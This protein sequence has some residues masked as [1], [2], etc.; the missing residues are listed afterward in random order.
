MRWL[1]ELINKKINEISC[2]QNFWCHLAGST[3][4]LILMSF[5]ILARPE[6]EFGYNSKLFS[7]LSKW[8]SRSISCNFFFINSFW[9][10]INFSAWIKLL[11]KK[12]KKNNKTADA[13]PTLLCINIHGFNHKTPQPN[14]SILNRI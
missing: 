2:Q 9:Y 3:V 1:V 14:I 8:L 5:V 6:R 13:V 4:W 10:P 11:N 12:L 7:C